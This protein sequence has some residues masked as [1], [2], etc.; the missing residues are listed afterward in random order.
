MKHHCFRFK[1]HCRW[2]GKAYYAE[3]PVGRDGFDLPKC[4]QA[5]Y[6]ARKRYVT[7]KTGPR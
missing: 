3:K 1:K 4:K 2:C 5:L 7:A 6:R